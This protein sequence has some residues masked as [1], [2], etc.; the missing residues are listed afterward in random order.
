MNQIIYYPKEVGKMRDRALIFHH[1]DLDGIGIKIV[2]SVA[3]NR[4]G[5]KEI[6]TFKCDYHS[7]NPIFLKRLQF[8]LQSEVTRRIFKK[9]D[10][11][12]KNFSKQ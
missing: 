6:E 7:I 3:A 4:L 1:T 11:S 9:V 10:L 5:Y 2:G 8:L 12:V